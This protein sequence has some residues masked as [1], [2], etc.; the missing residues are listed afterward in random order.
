MCLIKKPI[1]QIVPMKINIKNK[2]KIMKG[3]FN[4]PFKIKKI[5]NIKLKTLS[6]KIEG[7]KIK[8]LKTKKIIFKVA[9]LLIKKGKI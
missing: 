7:Y 9:H 2:F 4:N 3:N 8:F 1:L 5:Y 6:F